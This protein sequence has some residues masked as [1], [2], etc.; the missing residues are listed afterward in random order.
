MLGLFLCL[1]LDFLGG[2][3]GHGVGDDTDTA[4][5]PLSDVPTTDA[6]ESEEA[7]AED[8][9]PTPADPAAPAAEAEGKKDDDDRGEVGVVATARMASAAPR[10]RS[11]STC[12]MVGV[13]VLSLSK[14]SSRAR[15]RE[16]AATCNASSWRQL[17]RVWREAATD[18]L[19]SGFA[20]APAAAADGGDDVAGDDNDDE[21][22]DEGYGMCES[23]IM[24]HTQ[25]SSKKMR[26]RAP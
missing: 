1:L 20:F 22:E 12:F 14:L 11:A 4:E 17:G 10:T 19:A 21:E 9:A 24:P 7:E 23:A 26:S 18:W 16:R 25:S 2:R 8:C 6:V 15:T 3:E 5:R 13:D